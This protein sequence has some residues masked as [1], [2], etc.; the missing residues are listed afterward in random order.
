MLFPFSC[1]EHV[2]RED[3]VGWQWTSSLNLF[4]PSHPQFGAWPQWLLHALPQ[5]LTTAVWIVQAEYD[6]FCYR[7]IVDLSQ[8]HSL[9]WM[10]KLSQTGS[11]NSWSLE[12]VPGKQHVRLRGNNLNAFSLFEK[13][14]HSWV[15]WLLQGIPNMSA[16][17]PSIDKNSFFKNCNRIILHVKSSVH[18]QIHQD[19][20]ILIKL[21]PLKLLSSYCYNYFKA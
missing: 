19:L 18:L 17:H 2:L 12:N 7:K 1:L 8:D 14:S 20:F 11:S 21:T 5:C 4:I 3:W 10:T 13:H 6:K 15:P 16:R 9:P